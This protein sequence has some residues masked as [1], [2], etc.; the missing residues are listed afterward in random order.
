MSS[1]RVPVRA[2]L[3]S[4]KIALITMPFAPLA[5]PALG[6]SLLKPILCAAGFSVSIRYETLKFA[7]LIGCEAYDTVSSTDPKL[8]IGDW[9]FA[10]SLSA[11][12]PN[13]LALSTRDELLRL[14]GAGFVEQLLT[15]RE[16]AQ[17]F[18]R[19]V[20]AEIA[21]TEPH[22]VGFTNTF[23]QSVATLAAAKLLKTLRPDVVIV[24]GGAN[25]EGEMGLELARRFPFVDAFVSGEAEGVVV[26]LM[27]K[28]LAREDLAGLPGVFTPDAAEQPPEPVPLSSAGL[29]ALPFPDYDEFYRDIASAQL[30]DT[31]APRLLVEASRGC[32]WGAKHH[33]TFCGLNGATIAFRSK[34]PDRFIAELEYLRTTYGTSRVSAVDNIIDY[35][36]F[37]TVLPA[38]AKRGIE[39][40]IFFEVKAN[41]RRDQV[42]LLRAA[43]VN[44]VQ[45]GVESLDTGILRLMRKGVSALQN[46]QL[47]KWCKQYGIEP[48]WNLLYGFPGEDPAAYDRMAALIPLLTHL[49][50][51]AIAAPIRLDRFSPFFE[52][53]SEHAITN[54]RPAR[55]YADVF[56]FPND[57][58]AR[59]AYYFEFDYV[60]SRVPDAYAAGVVRAATTWIDEYANRDL[61]MLEAGGKLLIVDRRGTE[62][63]PFVVLSG[64][65]RAI[66]LAC[67]QAQTLE[68]ILAAVRRNA[69]G[70]QAD[71]ITAC[72]SNF[73]ASG[74]MIEDEQ[75]YLS[76]AITFSGGL[77]AIL[78]NQ[79][80][81]GAAAMTG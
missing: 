30:G 54:V 27:T 69:P 14:H 74:L 38:L 72:T 58:L 67:D 29:D 81:A 8:L 66:Y 50:P 61:V 35:K 63:R 22:I 7:K 49:P 31:F 43:G 48:T 9:I 16:P 13:A 33:C 68:A 17:R 37:E 32:W 56:D 40:E 53:P 19:E 44:H 11:N 73:V 75:K 10:P 3:Q 34:S 36:Y 25:C 70:A 59:L 52:N 62:S 51:P 24:V 76:L 71:Q 39:L 1:V 45:P 77:S 21:A 2:R 18:L 80:G 20:V 65:E 78:R 23:S 6:L 15:F 60:E 64:I 4:A 28:A 47:L 79:I 46:V 41:L 57:A 55:A 5:M 42:E 12:V 26:E